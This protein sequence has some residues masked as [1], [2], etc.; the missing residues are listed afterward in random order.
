MPK[1]APQSG[2]RRAL[3]QDQLVLFY[4]PIHDSKSRAIVAAEALLRARR[5]NG[6]IR[7]GEPIAAAAEEG[8]DLFRLDSWTVQRA[9]ADAAQWQKGAGPEVRMQVNLSPREF[10]NR[11]VAARLKKLVTTCGADPS[12]ITLEITETH[13]IVD[14]QKTRRV[15]EELKET[16]VELWADDFGT[17]HSS[18]SHL[19]YFPLDGLKLAGS[20]IKE[21]A[22]NGRAASMVRALVALAHE[23][24]MKVIA[25]GVENDGQLEMLRGCECDYIQGFLFSRPMPL[26]AFEAEL[27]RAA[28]KSD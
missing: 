23:L 3:D 13:H 4:Q 22:A 9:V 10:E 2:V 5:S 19:L 15:L 25:E 27:A 1:P 26:D 8:P 28:G 11:G 18:L 16:G 6:E 14:I 7:S 20:F 17:G 12:K 21:V 24:E